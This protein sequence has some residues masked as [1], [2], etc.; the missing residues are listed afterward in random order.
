LELIHALLHLDQFL[1]TIIVQYGASIYAI[2]FAIVFSETAILALFFLPGDPLLF[3]SGALAA[4]GAIKFWVLIGLLFIAAV[5]GSN[6]NY[7]LGNLIGK[8]VLTHDYKWLNRHALDS[9]NTF[10]ERHGAVTFLVSLFIPICRTFAPFIA[11][12]SN[13][14]YRKFQLFSTVGAALWVLVLISGGYFFG[15]IPIIRNHLNVIVLLGVGLGLAIPLVNAVVR[16]I[17]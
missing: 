6:L 15:N 5:L 16:Y 13:M 11:G 17:K 1:N 14:T 7:W 2:L 9:T 8:K 3:I 12:F 4:T 10:Y